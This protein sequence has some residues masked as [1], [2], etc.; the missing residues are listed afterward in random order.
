MT[1]AAQR[2]VHNLHAKV[3]HKNL[4]QVVD[5]RD[6]VVR[7]PELVHPANQLLGLRQGFLVGRRRNSHGR[8][9]RRFAGRQVL[10]GALGTRLHNAVVGLQRLVIVVNLRPRDLRNGRDAIEHAVD[11]CAPVLNELGLHLRVVLPHLRRNRFQVS[12]GILFRQ[13]FCRAVRRD[14]RPHVEVRKLHPVQDRVVVDV[15]VRVVRMPRVRMLLDVTMVV[16]LGIQS[17]RPGSLTHQVIVLDVPGHQLL[18]RHKQRDLHAVVLEQRH[19]RHLVRDEND[20]GVPHQVAVLEVRV[21]VANR[22]Q[23]LLR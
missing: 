6:V 3:L 7:A 9:H 19:H 14:V 21:L 20:G 4:L 12:L 22:N 16:A 15:V 23:L 8:R 17:T 5:R 2:L 11:V 18:G 1:V 10:H 13:V